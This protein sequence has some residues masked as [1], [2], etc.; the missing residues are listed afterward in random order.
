MSTCPFDVKIH[1]NAE[2]EE[3]YI[4]HEY[5]KT[6]LLDHERKPIRG[7]SVLHEE[8]VSAGT[9]YWFKESFEGKPTGYYRVKGSFCYSQDYYGD[10]DSELDIIYFEKV[11]RKICK[12]R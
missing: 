11:R 5:L 3:I 2:Y 1:W 12:S 6:P 8:C 10:W 9:D 7:S 4:E